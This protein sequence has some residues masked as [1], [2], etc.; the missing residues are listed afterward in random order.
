M[1]R[2]VRR[3][4]KSRLRLHQKRCLHEGGDP[5]YRK[6]FS[7]QDASTRS[8]CQHCPRPFSLCIG[9]HQTRPCLYRRGSR[10]GERGH[11][12]RSGHPCSGYAGHQIHRRPESVLLHFYDNKKVCGLSKS[13]NCGPQGGC[14]L[15]Q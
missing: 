4:V 10:A 9:H 6:K 15:F 14:S 7:A 13:I 5:D 12:P 8:R 11:E 2:K 3:Y 1:D